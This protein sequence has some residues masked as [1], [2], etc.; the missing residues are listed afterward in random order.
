MADT[1]TTTYTSG[2]S[3]SI[4]EDVEGVI[5]NITPHKTPFIASIGK[6]K[7]KSTLH[8]WLED[9]ITSPTGTN[10]A[11][12]G[13]DAT[14]TARDT[15]SR[16]TNYTQIMQDT[17]KLSATNDAVDLVGRKKE[18]KYQLEKSLKYLNTELEYACINNATAAAGDATTERQMKGLAGFITTN[19]ESY[20]TFADTND[21][22]EAKLMAMAEGIYENSDD[23]SFNLLCPPSQAR[24]I[25]GWDQN[26]RI[27]VNTNASEKTLVMA[28]MVLE[29]PFGR[30]KIVLDRY[31]AQVEDTAAMYDTV[32]LYEPSKFKVGW[33]RNWKTNELAKT[34]DSKKYQTVGEMTLIAKSEKAAAKAAKLATD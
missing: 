27:T 23:D 11:V 9:T 22:D 4:F 34:G 8:E 32:Y 17:F 10:K 24:K 31:I 2:M 15:P 3:D 25:A 21:F 28:V 5:Q 13:A 20:A 12:E 33:L 18:S 14:A 7:V 1:N 16:L 30:I 26:S 6:D 19:D 29:T